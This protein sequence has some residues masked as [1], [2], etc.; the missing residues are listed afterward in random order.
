MT[1]LVSNPRA[2]RGMIFP[3][4]RLSPEEKTRRQAEREELDRLLPPDR[5]TIPDWPDS[6]DC[7]TPV[8][9]DVPNVVVQLLLYYFDLDPR[10]SI[11]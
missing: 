11:N 7:A 5:R 8:Q 2:R 4:R 3:W 1:Q 6:N 10:L 9:E